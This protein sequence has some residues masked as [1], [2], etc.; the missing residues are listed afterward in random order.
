MTYTHINILGELE[1]FVVI[2]EKFDE[3]RGPI[4]VLIAKRFVPSFLCAKQIIGDGTFATQADIFHAIKGQLWG[5]HFLYF[6]KL[7]TV[8]HCFLP[9]KSKAVYDKV[10]LMMLLIA[11]SHSLM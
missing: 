11:S 4:L 8:V 5:M 7:L 3:F 10:P 9:G 1:E 2:N 6:G